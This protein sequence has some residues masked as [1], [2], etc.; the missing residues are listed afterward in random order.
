MYGEF[1]AGPDSA[2]LSEGSDTGAQAWA[3]RSD[4]P[5]DGVPEPGTL[6]LLG[7]GL[8]SLGAAALCRRNRKVRPAGGLLG[9]AD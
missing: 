5:V 3:V 7:L 9:G 6:G 4:Q 2:D 8:L 1:D